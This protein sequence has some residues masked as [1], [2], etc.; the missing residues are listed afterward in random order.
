MYGLSSHEE[1]PLV[2][3]APS[4]YDNPP[5]DS[6]GGGCT[7]FVFGVFLLA[8]LGGFA[9]AVS[10]LYPTWETYTRF[11]EIDAE[12]LEGRIREQFNDSASYYPELRIRYTPAGAA[13]REAWTYRLP[14]QRVTW[15]PEA[16]EVI[17][18]YPIGKRVRAWYDPA[19]PDRVVLERGVQ[20]W[21][22][23]VLLFPLPFFLIGWWGLRHFGVKARAVSREAEAMKNAGKPNQSSGKLLL[24]LGSIFFLAGA[25]IFYGLMVGM[26]LPEQ[27]ARNTFVET[28]C[29]VVAS[30][31]LTLRGDDSTTYRPEFKIRYRTPSFADPA[32]T[33]TYRI[34]NV[35]SSDFRA[36][37]AVLESF[38][39]GGKFPCW[40][41]PDRPRWVVIDRDTGWFPYLMLFLPLVFLGVGALMIGIGWNSLP[42]RD[43]SQLAMPDGV[44]PFAASA[45]DWRSTTASDRPA[46]DPQ[47]VTRQSPP[48]VPSLQLPGMP[49]MS[50]TQGEV[51]PCR[52]SVS[53]SAWGQVIGLVFVS[54]FWNGITGVFVGIAVNSHLRGKPEWFL[55]VFIT[56]FV[57]IGLFL[58]CATLRLFL[59]AWGI[60][61]AI[62]EISHHP[63]EL[64]GRYS[65]YVR[66]SG[67]LTVNSLVVSLH[68]TEKVSYRQGT[69]TRTETARV[70]AAELFRQE[71][72][73]IDRGMPLEIRTE[74]SAPEGSMHS[75]LGTHNSVDWKLVVKGDIANW[76]DFE[77][78]FPVV[79]HP[80]KQIAEPYGET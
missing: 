48:R 2:A 66:Q 6:K 52:L 73:E 17:D 37:E 76:P 27:R 32:E 79:V 35:S 18:R 9:L 14:E 71:G 72:F 45:G 10:L 53:A 70:F 16:W 57:L 42:P 41:D 59:V 39:V 36:E 43:A 64:G 1:M 33:W 77:A 65:V 31:M 58:I 19:S 12:I 13:P 34:T 23:L 55:T 78:E 44:D 30:R 38:P 62:V 60:R 5:I 74:L 4:S 40:Y 21:T 49:L 29:E 22:V 24:T 20:W 26:V 25:G 61:P 15:H 11:A 8:G 7:T 68:C 63:L 51:L 3:L 75:L 56:P 80:N 50:H 46:N 47:E 67:P 28:E 69:D 54:L